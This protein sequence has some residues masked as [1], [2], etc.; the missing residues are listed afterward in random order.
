MRKDQ[1]MYTRELPVMRASRK[2]LVNFHRA[3]EPKAI[4]QIDAAC[5]NGGQ[6]SRKADAGALQELAFLFVGTLLAALFGES[7]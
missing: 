7:N 4:P 2:W 1:A 3:L 5:K 6:D